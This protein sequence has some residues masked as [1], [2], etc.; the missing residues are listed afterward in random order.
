M[1]ANLVAAKKRRQ[2]PSGDA[3]GSWAARR[4]CR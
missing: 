2:R 3:P 4:R 1:P